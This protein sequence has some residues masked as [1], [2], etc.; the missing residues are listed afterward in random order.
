MSLLV[1]CTV[2]VLWDWP[3]FLNRL[4][5][6]RAQNEPTEG[7]LASKGDMD[8]TI[9]LSRLRAA[10]WVISNP[11]GGW[12]HKAGIVTIDFYSFLKKGSA[13]IGRALI[14][15]LASTAVRQD[16]YNQIFL[17]FRYN[18]IIESC[19]DNYVF[20]V[21]AQK[22]AIQTCISS[23]LKLDMVLYLNQAK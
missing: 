22:W 1:Y 21:A 16:N 12:Y 6:Q 18:N 7:S 10:P 2:E 5:P 4:L 3:W 20:L 15:F 19:D 14:L 9:G 23:N 17:S 11:Q 8:W 13:V